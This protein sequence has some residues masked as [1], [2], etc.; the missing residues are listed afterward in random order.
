MRNRSLLNW[1]WL[2]LCAAILSNSA[3][4]NELATEVLCGPR[5][6]KRV[7]D[8]YALP[9]ED[10]LQVARSFDVLNEKKGSRLSEISSQLGGRGIYCETLRVQSLSQL[11]WNYPVV[12]HLGSDKGF[13]H[14]CV[15]IPDMTSQKEGFVRVFDGNHGDILAPSSSWGSIRDRVVL[16]TSPEPIDRES[17]LGLV[18][19]NQQSFLLFNAPLAWSIVFA[20]ASLCILVSLG[21]QNEK[22]LK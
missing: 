4:A 7:M 6:V 20:L 22:G 8:F 14:F 16:L 12:V 19:K 2:F 21:F 11:D 17:C 5:C 18:S 15:F 13:G 9:K 3:C 10:L 1:P